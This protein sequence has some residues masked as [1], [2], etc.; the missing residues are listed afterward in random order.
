MLVEKIIVDANILISAYGCDGEVRRYW[1]DSL[2]AYKIIV[3]PEILIE[4]EAR[5]RNGEFNL[6]DESIKGVLLDILSRCEVVRP[7]PAHDPK[8]PDA[9][10]AHLSALARHAH[11][12]GVFAEWLLTGDEALRRCVKIG[13]CKITGIGEFCN[14]RDFASS[15]T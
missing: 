7:N 9:K 8:F 10:D 3:S 5:L 11:P 6:P 15:S 12:D 14:S 13:N 2:R 4:V 1:R